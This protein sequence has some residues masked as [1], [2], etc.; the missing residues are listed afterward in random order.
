[1]KLINYRTD[2]QCREKWTTSLDPSL[3]ISG[4]KFTKEE[5]KLLL[6]LL[7]IYGLANWSQLSVWFIGRTDAQ[8]LRRYKQ[9]ELNANINNIEEEINI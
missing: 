7:P 6:K 3:N 9:I 4:D 1:M 2:I 5:D 8:L